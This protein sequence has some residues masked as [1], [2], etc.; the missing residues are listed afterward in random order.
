MKTYK[1]K[2]KEEIMSLIL[3]MKKEFTIKEI[4]NMLNKEV[5]L[6][7]IYRFVDKL[8]EDNKLIKS[9][10]K[11]NITYYQYISECHNDSHINL[12]CTKCGMIYHIDCECM[13]ELYNHI[14]DEHK[15]SINTNNIIIEGL[16][17]NC[18]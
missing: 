16:C 6:T 1:T 13:S 7:T 9:I 15:F 14:F 12:K 8:V 2:G 18:S 3:D 4:Y 10:G 17:K 11:D 5:G